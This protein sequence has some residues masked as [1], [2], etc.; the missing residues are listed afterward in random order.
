M[1]FI[2]AEHVVQPLLIMHIRGHITA[3]VFIHHQAVH[4]QSMQ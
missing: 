3:R 1:W 4:L 2:D